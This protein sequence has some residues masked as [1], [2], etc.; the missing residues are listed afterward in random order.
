MK[1]KYLD[2]LAALLKQVRPELGTSHRLD[3]KN[4][5]GAVG[6]YVN[7]NIFISCGKFGVALRLP[8]ATLDILFQKEDVTHL[9]YFSG[10]HAKKEYAVLPERI[11]EN[12]SHLRRLVD[13]SVQYVVRASKIKNRAQRK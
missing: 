12:S 10:G 8:S 2:E 3:F 1:S 9:K 11:L 4:V 7:G 6:G 13:E 5:F